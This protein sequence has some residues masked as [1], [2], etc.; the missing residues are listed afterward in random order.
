M[1]TN[2]LAQVQIFTFTVGVIPALVNHVFHV[3]SRLYSKRL[4]YGVATHFLGH[5][6]EIPHWGTACPSFR[7]KPV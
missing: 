7:E 4:L 3:D 5:M 2:V 1:M 6:L